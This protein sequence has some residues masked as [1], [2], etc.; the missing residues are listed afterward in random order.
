MSKLERAKIEAR[1]KLNSLPLRE[2]QA[3]VN[4]VL[5]A[6]ELKPDLSPEIDWDEIPIPS[7]GKNA[8]E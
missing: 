1:Q 3:I 2:A 4:Q 6:N 8:D 7:S 5:G